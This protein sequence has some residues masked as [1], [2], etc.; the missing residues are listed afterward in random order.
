MDAIHAQE[1]SEIRKDMRGI[2]EKTIISIVQLVPLKTEARIILLHG[3]RHFH[4]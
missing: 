2:L 3:H 4:K 1:F